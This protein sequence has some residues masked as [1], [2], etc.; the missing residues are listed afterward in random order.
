MEKLRKTTSHA[1]PEEDSSA[2]RSV[3][4]VARRVA[5]TIG[6]DFFC[7]IAKHL[8]KSLKADCVL[9]GEFVGGQV[10]RVRTLGS[11]MDAEAPTFE[12][13]LAG[14]ASAQIAQ[15]KHTLC[16][17]DAQTR[18]PN[19]SLLMQVRAHAFIGV[20]L[21]TAR[22]EPI[23]LMAALYR[24]PV[25]SLGSAKTLLDIFAAR[26]GAELSR[27]HEDDA[28]RESEQRH[29][30]FIALNPDAMWRVEFEQPIDINLPEQ[31]QL[32]RIYRFG[33]L[34]ECNDSLARM[35]GVE[36]A[37]QLI[38]SRI[39]DIAPQSDPR[40][41]EA[42]LMAIRSGYK[43][44][45]VETHAVD[46]FGNK[47]HLLRSQWGI[48]EEGVLE[49]LWGTTR[50]ITDLKR[51]ELELDASERRMVDL[52]ESVKLAVLMVD[53]TGA[54]QFCN[55]YLCRLTGW[56]S[57][58]VIGKP[59]LDLMI[60]P[61]D[62]DRLRTLFESADS[63][64][65]P[66]H[67]ESTVVSPEGRQ[68]LFEWDRTVLRD[69]DGTITVCANL[70]RDVTEH[71]KL[72]EHFRQSQKLASLGRVA[73]GVAHDFNNLLTVILG[74]SSS[75]IEHCEPGGSSYVGLNEIRKAAAKGAEL[76]HRLLAFGRRQVLRP[77]VLNLNALITDTEQMLGRL[78]GEDI[79]LTSQL[80]PSLGPVLI[81]PGSFHQVLM[82][83]S[84][85]ARDAMPRGGDLLITASNV[86]IETHGPFSMAVPPGEY[87]Q[88][89]FTDTGIGMS[90]DIRSQIF[91]PFFT[92]K[93][94]GHGTGLGL[95]TVYGIVEQSGGRIVVETAVGKGS[96]F[97][98][99]FPRLKD[100]PEPSVESPGAAPL[101]RGSECI[102]LVED[103]DDV[104][105]I[106]AEMLT[107]LGY[108]VITAQGSESAL[109]LI[110]ER[111]RT[112]HL[113]LTD[114]VMPGIGGLELARLAQAYQP[115]L[116]VLF[117]SGSVTAPGTADKLAQSGFAY[118]QK[119][120]TRADLA[121]YLRRLLNRD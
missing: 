40:I 81:D 113:L 32:D 70:G 28:L 64:E 117:M 33:Y 47:K 4:Q 94:H 29:R 108:S 101:P 90:E 14:S 26:A 41:R 45:V 10:E 112:I 54:I 78:I 50:D 61:E 44:T 46:R 83:L 107:N 6:A 62:R 25:T 96:T 51:S 18:F 92:T 111:S 87:V 71:R 109:E 52:L 53:L 17:A 76:T 11:W 9:I 48:V 59:W 65:G 57:E 80:D 19:D 74:Y 3:L 75:L 105:Q 39:G 2:D 31:E 98:L 118:L 55:N 99:F 36:K 69:A 103:R 115:E 7:A 42:N 37:Q 13:P 30:A 106:T 116:K 12:Y 84:V 20:P 88:V 120:F 79:R 91:E 49:R 86:E 66:I 93:E 73:G 60:P 15:G 23:G 67:F 24:R 58:Q 77:E 82:N 1:E 35:V 27:K 56:D 38:G 85:N 22:G 104:R 114:V 100:Q 97:R 16:R 68:W 63:Q 95:S 34:A 121:G 21:T 43:F 72:E 5:A 119:P 8:A 89:A 110:R 102:L